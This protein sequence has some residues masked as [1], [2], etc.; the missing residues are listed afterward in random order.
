MLAWSSQNALPVQTQHA[1][2]FQMVCS[3]C[4]QCPFKKVQPSL[5][6]NGRN[7]ENVYKSFPYS[8]GN[9]EKEIV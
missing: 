2:P 4:G 8:V 3:L 5:L 9:H 1:N 6:S 7:Q